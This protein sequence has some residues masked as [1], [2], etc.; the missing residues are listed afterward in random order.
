MKH[1]VYA[2]SQQLPEA[3][4]WTITLFISIPILVIIVVA[5]FKK[6]KNNNKFKG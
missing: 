5:L 6:N 2:V 3:P 1:D 4:W